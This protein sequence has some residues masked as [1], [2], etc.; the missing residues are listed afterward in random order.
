MGHTTSLMMQKTSRS[1]CVSMTKHIW[2]D[3]FHNVISH[4]VDI[5]WWC[6]LYAVSSGVLSL[7][8]GTRYKKSGKL[9][10]AGIMTGLRSERLN[11]QNSL[12]NHS[13]IMQRIISHFNLRPLLQF[14]DGV[15]TASAPR[16]VTGGATLTRQSSSH[17]ASL[18]IKETAFP[19]WILKQAFD[20][21]W[22]FNSY[23]TK[24]YQWVFNIFSVNLP[25]NRIK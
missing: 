18:V 8:M 3:R 12:R 22:Y 19:V 5:M 17:W 20:F 1:H 14:V 15:S 2:M 13:Q 6:F 21:V 25:V 9:M 11:M 23:V 24:S 7:V 10:P 16:W 4:R